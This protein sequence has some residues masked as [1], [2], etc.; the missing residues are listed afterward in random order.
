MK[1]AGVVLDTWKAPIFKR[2]LEAAGYSF[3]EH[4]GPLFGCSTL[5]VEY[6]WAH[7]LKPIVDAA[8]QE[9]RGK[10]P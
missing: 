10:Q 1:T 6:E 3:T 8:N 9:C 5:R 7:K 4:P 2:H